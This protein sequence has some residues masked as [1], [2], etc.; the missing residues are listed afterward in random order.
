M[1]PSEII[2]FG[3]IGIGSFKRYVDH[4]LKEDFSEM[5]LLTSKQ[6]LLK[7]LNTET[8]IITRTPLWSKE[9]GIAPRL[10]ISFASTVKRTTSKP[11]KTLKIP[12]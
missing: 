12:L 1:S 8:G 7:F 10:K 4:A 6:S 9:I 5:N 2:L 3:S 11:C